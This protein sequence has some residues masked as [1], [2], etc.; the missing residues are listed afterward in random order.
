MGVKWIL[1][2]FLAFLNDF[3]GDFGEEI[4]FSNSFLSERMIFLIEFRYQ[5]ISEFT[6]S[7]FSLSIWT[8]SFHAF[9]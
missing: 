9:D 8:N 3:F 7:V 6:L 2:N 1:Q 5:N 4:K